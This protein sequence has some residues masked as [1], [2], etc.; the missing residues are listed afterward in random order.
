MKRISTYTLGC[1][2]NFAETSA[3][4]QAF[5]AQGYELVPFGEEADVTII[6]TCS[7]TEHA[8]A[9]CRNVVRRAL[10][11]SPK[12]FVAVVGCYAQLA[13]EELASIEGVDV[14]LGAKE[15]FDVMKYIGDEK[16]AEAQIFV[17][18]IQT[19]DNFGF[20]HSIAIGGK[21]D[22]TRAY[23]KVQ[24]GCNYNCSYCTIPL[25]RGQS[26]SESI[27]T[28]ALQAKTLIDAGYQEIVLTGVNI[29]DY[30]NKPDGSK[31][32]SSFFDLLKAL[33]ELPIPRL[34]ISSIEPNLLT[35]EMIDFIARSK[36]IVPHFH[37]P[38]QSGSADVLRW[39]R[40]RYNKELYRARCEEVAAKI[41]NVCV[42]ADVIVGFPNETDEHFEETY[43]FI[44]SLPIAYLH[45]FTFSKR[46][47]THAAEMLDAGKFQ[48]V[49]SKVK[50]ARSQKLHELSFFK[51]KAFVSRFVG[52]QMDV[53]FEDEFSDDDE[54]NGER[55]SSEKLRCY[56][57]TANYLR[58]GVE[59]PSKE[60]ARERL[61]GKILPVSLLGIDEAL[62]ATGAL[63]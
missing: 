53:L 59:V 49:P 44:E 51:K 6:N 55:T 56:G 62:N 48:E 31:G 22:Q 13:P 40:R 34:R 23:L 21:Q 9:K 47:N 52:K 57:H 3:L 63:A 46:P 28:L 10:K 58:V 2:L 37:L 8:D 20:G 41:P 24:D 45:V 60:W 5:L 26:R 43:R 36:R 11:K 12:S 50:Q 16:N 27:E 33:D 54:L 39:M 19:V 4:A 15:K 30:G 29:G 14:V 32:E 1:K 35:S 7:V 42:G 38:L 18:D 17:S 25:A 61:V